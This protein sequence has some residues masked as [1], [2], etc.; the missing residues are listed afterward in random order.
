MAILLGAHFMDALVG[1]IVRCNAAPSRENG[2]ITTH[3]SFM[4]TW[5]K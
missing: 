2:V 5:D 1:S 4:M 3:E